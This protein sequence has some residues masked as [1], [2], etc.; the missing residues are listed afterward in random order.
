MGS[1]PKATPGTPW[2]SML[3][4][5]I[6][7]GAS[8][9]GRPRNGPEQDDQDLGEAAGQAVAQEHPDVR[10][11][12]AALPDGDDDGREVVVG[13]HQVRRLPRDL[14][15]PLAHRDADVGPAQRRARRSRRPRSWPPR[16]RGP[17]TPRRCPPS[18]RVGCAR[19]PRSARPARR[20]HRAPPSPRRPPRSSRSTMPSSSAI[21]AGGRRVVAG[22]QDGRG[23]RRRGTPGPPR[24]RPPG[25]GRR[26]R[27]G[28]AA[29]SRSSGR[30]SGGRRPLSTAAA[31]GRLS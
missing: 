10:V 18:A 14:G 21:G 5:R 6:C 15:A 2:V 3:I 19:R 26:W 24:P 7:P 4:H 12:P 9:T 30:S 11:D 13:Q 17:A 28:R 22:D 25:A 16:P 27:R 8:G 29:P 20:G 1:P 23:C 31:S